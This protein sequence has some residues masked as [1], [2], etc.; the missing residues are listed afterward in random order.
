ML[1][2]E[3]GT[4]TVG[5]TT[6][7]VAVTA[8]LTAD[9]LPSLVAVAVTFPAGMSFVGVMLALPFSAA[10]PVPRLLPSLSNNSTVAPAS[11]VT[12]TGVLVLALPVK[13]V[14]ITGLATTVSFTTITST[15][16]S[17]VEPSGYVT[18]T[19]G[20]TVPGFDVSTSV[21]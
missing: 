12:S 4:S 19:V 11:A 3:Y 16:P 2:F 17:T 20:F 6:V 5:A 21:V 13:S 15:G 10:T 14:L 9:V 8:S 7:A 1:A 18:R